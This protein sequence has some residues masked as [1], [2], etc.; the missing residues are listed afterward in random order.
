MGPQGP[1]LE[2]PEGSHLLLD[3]NPLP[4]AVTA[5]PRPVGEWPVIRVLGTCPWSLQPRP[6]PHP[7]APHSGT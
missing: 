5:A 7:T 3:T 4:A 2:Q 6:P 1:A